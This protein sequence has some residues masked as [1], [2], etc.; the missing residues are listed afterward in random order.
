MNNSVAGEWGGEGGDD[1]AR[2][3]EFVSPENDVGYTSEKIL[4]LLNARFVFILVPI[5]KIINFTSSIDK[6]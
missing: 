1:A 5:C 3:R 4:C 2:V 6:C